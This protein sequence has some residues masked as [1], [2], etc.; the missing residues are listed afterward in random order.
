MAS[1]SEKT[2]VLEQFAI[3][4]SEKMGLNWAKIN[5]RIPKGVHHTSYPT[6]CL[7]RARAGEDARLIMFSQ[8]GANYSS[9][10]SIGSEWINW[11]EWL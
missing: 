5:P 6:I 11:S 3:R 7:D 9:N 1:K 10:R 2:Y 4:E 8:R